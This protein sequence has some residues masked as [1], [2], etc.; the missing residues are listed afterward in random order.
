MRGG[1]GQV[2][3]RGCFVD[4]NDPG[5]RPQGLDLGGELRFELFELV[6]GEGIEA[7]P[8]A[9][10]A[11]FPGAALPRD[12]QVLLGDRQQILGPAERLDLPGLDIGPL[13][14]L[15]RLAQF[16]LTTPDDPLQP[17][18]FCMTIDGI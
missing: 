5:S 9:P 10:A 4:A 7:A 17:R 3:L 16:R 2:S 15:T 18:K 13:V 14:D 6:R 8:A 1:I 11:D 12:P